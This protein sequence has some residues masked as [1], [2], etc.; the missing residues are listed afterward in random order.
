MPAEMIRK[1]VAQ[2]A[3]DLPSWVP[4]YAMAVRPKP[5]RDTCGQVFQAS[6]SVGPSFAGLTLQTLC[7]ILDVAEKAG[8]DFA[9]FSDYMDGYPPTAIFDIMLRVGAVYAPTGKRSVTALWRT[10]VGDSSHGVYPAPRA[11]QN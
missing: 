3:R 6:G 2:G 9:Q 5:Y 1:V 4:D 8:E 10:M 7:V 11:L